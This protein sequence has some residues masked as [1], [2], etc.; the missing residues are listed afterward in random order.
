MKP[1]LPILAFLFGAIPLSTWAQANSPDEF[2]AAFRTAIQE[3]SPEKLDAI[4]YSAGMSEADKQLAARVQQ[5]VFTDKE[6]DSVSLMPLPEDF[7]TVFI[8]RGKKLEPTY[9]PTGLIQVTY[10]GTGNGI[11]STSAPYAVIEGRYFLI[12]SKSTDLGWSG[13]PDKTIT[14]MVMGRGQDKVQIKAKWNASGVDQERVFKSPSSNFM[15]QHFNEITVTSTED[16]T[17]VTLTIL[18]SGK[19]IYVSEPLKGKGT[20]EYKRKS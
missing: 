15:G 10:K 5:G 7:Q 1:L 2:I 4:T 12:S 19:Q 18:E 20:I 9:T 8:M 14:F 6:I 3:K 16:D 11:N 13:P 17:D